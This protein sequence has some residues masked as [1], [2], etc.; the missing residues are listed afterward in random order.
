MISNNLLADI[1]IFD[2]SRRMRVKMECVF[3]SRGQTVL[4]VSV[5]FRNVFCPKG[6]FERQRRLA[7]SKVEF[8]VVF[9]V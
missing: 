2:S 9:R 6:S 8:F 3:Y 5:S 4:K 7:L 1:T